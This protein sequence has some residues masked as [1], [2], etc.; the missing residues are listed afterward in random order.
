MEIG[1]RL[2]APMLGRLPGGEE[3]GRAN[4]GQT[5]PSREQEARLRDLQKRE[6]AARNQPTPT[7]EDRA[8]EAPTR[9]PRRDLP[10][11]DALPPSRDTDS[12]LTRPYRDMARLGADAGTSPGTYLKDQA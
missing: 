6:Q 5:P 2:P 9:A 4:E 7:A 1:N 10:P 3:R 12:P 8:Q 11:Q